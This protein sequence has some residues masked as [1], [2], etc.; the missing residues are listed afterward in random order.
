[1]LPKL[2]AFWNQGRLAKVKPNVILIM[3]G[4]NDVG[5]GYD[6]NQGEGANRLKTLMD[7]IYALPGLGTPTIFPANIPPHRRKPR[8][9]AN[10]ASFN[11]AVPGIAADF[12]AQGKDIHFVDQFG[13][14]DA[15]YTED[16]MP[17]NLHPNS[18]GNDVMARQWFNA[19]ASVA[20]QPFFRPPHAQSQSRLLTVGRGQPGKEMPAI[21]AKT[22]RI[23][24]S[25]NHP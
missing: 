10:V 6:V 4:T 7:T 12:R 3:I 1:M 17:D 19:I 24:L 8:D 2:P 9:T 21:N 14:L 25:T 5:W 13:P 18:K 15:A 11:A 20:K 16:M 23:S 22:R